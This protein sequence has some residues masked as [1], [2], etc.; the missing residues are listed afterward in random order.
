MASTEDLKKALTVEHFNVDPSEL[1]AEKEYVFWI[2]KLTIY[3]TRLKADDGQK[4]EIL[5]NKISA[6]TYGYI[7]D[8]ANYADAVKKFDEIFKKKPNVLY[9]K[10]KLNT[11]DQ[12]PGGINKCLC[13]EIEHVGKVM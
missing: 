8:A 6:D 7:E 11:T 2:R 12:S 10:Y 1:N 4:L 9:A 13:F 5:I 3:L